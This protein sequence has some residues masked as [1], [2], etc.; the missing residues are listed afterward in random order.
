M[1]S[2]QDIRIRGYETNDLDACRQLWIELTEWH[3]RIYEDNSI[4]GSDPARKFNEHLERVGPLNIWIA[5][6]EG[7]TVGMVGLIP[8]DRE[9]EL[10]PLIVSTSYRGSGVGRRLVEAV[11]EAARSRGLRLVTTRPVARNKEA[12]Q[13]FHEMGFN[14]LGQLELFIELDEKK[15]ERWK[16]GETLADREFLV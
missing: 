4:G 12:I 8:G 5:E 3:R 14:I 6:S 9:A 13:F 15:R 16:A 11:V 10:E 7:R 1:A 2:Q